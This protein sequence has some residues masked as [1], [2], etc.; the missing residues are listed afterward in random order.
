MGERRTRPTSH[1]KWPSLNQIPTGDIDNLIGFSKYP[2][3]IIV[4]AGI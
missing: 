1:E 4:P 3:E 2:I